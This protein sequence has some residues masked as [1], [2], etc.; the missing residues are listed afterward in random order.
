MITKWKMEMMTMNELKRA[1][2]FSY[3]YANKDH[4]KVANVA[5]ALHRE[6]C[7]NAHQDYVD[8][9]I[10]LEWGQAGT[11]TVYIWP[12]E[13]K[14]HIPLIFKSWE[15]FIYFCNI[16]EDDNEQ[17]NKEETMDDVE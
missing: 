7:K 16:W 4:K 2:S 10:V 14:G 17:E 8:S 9:N 13:C 5:E 3:E 11:V 12:I 6:L 1:F 15:N